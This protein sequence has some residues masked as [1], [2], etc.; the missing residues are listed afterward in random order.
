M[1]RVQF[2][3]IG[4]RV[5]GLG[6]VGSVGF[7]RFNAVRGHIIRAYRDK[8]RLKGILGFGVQRGFM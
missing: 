2:K 6:F 5:E 3:V 4:F 8:K 1:A 7:I